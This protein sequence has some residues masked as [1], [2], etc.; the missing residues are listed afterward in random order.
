MLIKSLFFSRY[1]KTIKCSVRYFLK[2]NL[3]AFYLATK[4]P[5]CSAFNHVER[6]RN[7]PLSHDLA[8]VVL[9][10]DTFESHLNN[11]N[12]MVD[13]E[14]EMKNF[15]QAGEVLAEIWSKAVID[16]YPIVA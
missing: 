2:H 11:K 13:H 15:A 5:G 14:L 1:E 10:H 8:G 9:L 16:N 4:A 12:E 6:W 3:D 7:T